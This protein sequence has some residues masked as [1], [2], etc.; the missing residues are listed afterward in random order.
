LNKTALHHAFYNVPVCISRII[1]F[2][3]SQLSPYC[4]DYTSHSA[5]QA[6]VERDA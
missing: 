1:G 6:S 4:V 2:K 3:N 5:W